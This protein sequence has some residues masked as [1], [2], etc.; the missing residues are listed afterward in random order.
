VSDGNKGKYR[1]YNDPLFPQGQQKLLVGH[2]GQSFLDAGYVHSP[3]IPLQ[4]T[5]T[6]FWFPEPAPCPEPSIVDRIATLDDP[7]GELA[8]RVAAWDA[9][10]ARHDEA[11]REWLKEHPEAADANPVRKLPAPGPQFIDP[12]DFQLRKGL[13]TRFKK[14]VAR[15]DFFAKVD[16]QSL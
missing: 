15:P 10:V 4:T 8:K 14:L 16:I 12:S 11:Y 1:V 2:K 13:S 5:G 9:W 3:Y 7:D 6:G